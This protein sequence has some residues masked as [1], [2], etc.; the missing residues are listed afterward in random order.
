MSDYP[1]PFC[2]TVRPAPTTPETL[3][4][5]TCRRPPLVCSGYQITEL[6]GRGG[7]GIVY[8]GQRLTDGKPVAIKMMSLQLGLDWKGYELFER[9]TRVLQGLRH[10]AL[11]ELFA[12]EKDDTGRL[13]LVRERFDGGSLEERI[14][15]GQRRLSPGELRDLLTRMLEL[16]AYL[17]GQVPPVLHRDI[18][19][20]NIMFR[21][22]QDWDPVLV[23]FDTV[24]LPGTQVKRTT[25]VVS[26]GTTA[27]E[28]LGGNVSPASDLFSLGATMLYVATQTHPDE[29]PARDGRFLVANHLA[30][31][32]PPL[33]TVLLKLVEPDV[34][35]RYARAEDV[36]RDLTAPSEPMLW[37]ADEQPALVKE[38]PIAAAFQLAPAGTEAIVPADVDPALAALAAE[39]AQKRQREAEL[40]ELRQKQAEEIAARQKDAAT[41]KDTIEA[42]QRAEIAVCSV[43]DSTIFVTGMAAGTLGL[44]ALV[45]S[46]TMG[47]FSIVGPA[48]AGVLV[49]AAGLYG[50]WRLLRRRQMRQVEQWLEGLPFPV[51]GYIAAL[52]TNR[53]G[54]MTVSIAS[55]RPLPPAAVL[56]DAIAALGLATELKQQGPNDVAFGPTID[57]MNGS[58]TDRAGIAHKWFRA[59]VDR[60]LVPL[61]GQVGPLTVFVTA[62]KKSDWRDF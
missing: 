36:L 35:R 13:V 57:G 31:L 45:L 12:F 22:P 55:K 16:L 59:L 3:A 49:L 39:G 44:S 26:P 5:P 29:L 21:T 23:D 46:A 54:T 60:V 38:P 9:S 17:H 8:G 52:G 6:L 50:G 19:A 11:P 47:G 37:D 34:A 7:M 25:L 2:Q 24:A 48:V 58:A 27:P 15:G 53:F 62:T 30:W 20:P 28:Q 56:T 10:H 4:C 41:A 51:V 42:R 40:L 32:A 61:H 1:C 14:V 43:S 18:K 33:P